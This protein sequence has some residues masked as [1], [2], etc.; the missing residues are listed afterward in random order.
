[1]ETLATGKNLDDPKVKSEI[2]AQVLPLIADVP[3]PIERDAYRQRLARLLRVSE[4]TLFA[5]TRSTRAGRPG[6]AKPAA[7]AP[8]QG[9]KRP[10]GSQPGLLTSSTYAVEAHALGVLMRRPDLLYRV[11]RALHE[12]GLSSLSADDFQHVDHQAIIRLLSQ[13]L[14]QDNAEP[15]NY[16][17]NGLSLPM[18]EIA[19]SLLAHTERLDPSDERVL[20]DVLRAILDLRQRAVRQSMEYLRFLMEDAQEQ[21]DLKATQYRQTMV[22]HTLIMQR[23]N[24]AMGHYTSRVVRAS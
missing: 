19:D 14:D 15:L 12:H 4:E 9:E 5:A 23:L 3:S 21:G 8:R 10:A 17:L 16:V 24:K 2:A 11:N 1:M 6:R 7:T 18:M 20:A 22:Q 13:S